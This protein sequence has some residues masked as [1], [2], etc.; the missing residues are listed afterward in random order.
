MFEISK[1]KKFKFNQLCELFNFYFCL[2]FKLILYHE[3]NQM[4]I[5]TQLIHKILN[6]FLLISFLF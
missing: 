1:K 2:N 3:D 5:P 6:N 4:E